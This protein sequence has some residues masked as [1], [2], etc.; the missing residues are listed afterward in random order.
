MSEQVRQGGHI[1][2]DQLR[3]ALRD[4]DRAL[5]AARYVMGELASGPQA[6]LAAFVPL[7][8]DQRKTL[9]AALDALDDLL[10]LLR[11][12]RDNTNVGVVAPAASC[13][14]LPPA[15]TTPLPSED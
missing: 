8:R 1:P 10:V 15:A 11:E 12:M 5:T 7:H 9:T 3:L 13:D 6:Y 14:A 4:G 2:A